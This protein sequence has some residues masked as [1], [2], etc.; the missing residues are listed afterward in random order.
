MKI[1]WA[2][3]SPLLNRLFFRNYNSSFG[4]IPCSRSLIFTLSLP[5]PSNSLITR[6]NTF[7][8]SPLSFHILQEFSSIKCLPS[9]FLHLRL[10]WFWFR[11]NMLELPPRALLFA[12]SG[13]V[14]NFFF[15]YQIWTRLFP[16]SRFMTR[17]GKFS[18]LEPEPTL[19]KFPSPVQEKF[20][21]WTGTEIWN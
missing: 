12:F 20:I 19:N 10:F 4:F 2:F 16:L 6:A 11:S 13:P 7:S 3:Y 8:F 9:S 14:L 21:S 17:N 18:S 15:W 1:K 5:P